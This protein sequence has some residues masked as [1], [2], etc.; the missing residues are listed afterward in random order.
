MEFVDFAALCGAAAA[1][2]S[3]AC[4]GAWHCPGGPWT[5]LSHLP[6]HRLRLIIGLIL[7]G[8]FLLDIELINFINPQHCHK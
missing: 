6:V 8:S 2:I 7:S 1:D 5:R 4:G 3:G